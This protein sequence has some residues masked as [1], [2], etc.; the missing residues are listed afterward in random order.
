[1]LYLSGKT[2]KI[3]VFHIKQKVFDMKIKPI[4]KAQDVLDALFAVP[5]HYGFIFVDENGNPV[6]D[7]LPLYMIADNESGQI[8]ITTKAPVVVDVDTE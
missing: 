5:P 2:D 4:N 3:Y 8:V 7:G 6:L 1:M